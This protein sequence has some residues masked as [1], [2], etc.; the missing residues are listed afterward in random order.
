MI[1]II[2]SVFSHAYDL[3][4]TLREKD[5]QEIEAFGMN[6]RRTLFNCFRKSCYRKTG[7]INGNVA[8]MWGVFGTPLS[9]DGQPWLLT[10]TL[11]ETISPLRFAKIYRKEVHLMSQMFPVLENYVDSNYEE[12]IKMLKLASF[13]VTDPVEINGN[14]FYKYSLRA[15]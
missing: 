1:E 8:A 9:S 7:L 11:V 15:I 10:G 13:E 12:A 6:P 2:P 4:L 5:K 14:L 3:S